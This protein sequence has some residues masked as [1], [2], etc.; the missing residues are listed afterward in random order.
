M[1]G[2]V[3][4]RRLPMASPVVLMQQPSA[5]PSRFTFGE[6][7]GGPTD[8]V[9]YGTLRSSSKEKIQKNNRIGQAGRG[10]CGV[11]RGGICGWGWMQPLLAVGN[12][13]RQGGGLPSKTSNYCV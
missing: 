2:L 3:K 6:R 5:E 10:R 13:N 1:H 12:F 8:R 7:A 9:G 4:K 11:N